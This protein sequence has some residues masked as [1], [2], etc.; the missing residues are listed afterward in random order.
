[1]VKIIVSILTVTFLFW[2]RSHAQESADSTTFTPYEL[3]SSYY[4]EGFKPFRKGNAYTGLSFSLTDK[5]LTN[6][7]KIFGQVINGDD[8]N[9]N[10]LFKGGYYLG[11]YFMVGFNFNYY[12]KKITGEVFVDPDSIQANSIT[13]GYGFAPNIRS[14]IP[15]TANERFSFFVALGLNFGV[16]NTLDRNITNLDEIS[17][18]YSTEYTFG[19]GISPGVTFFAMENFAFEVQ[20]NVLGYN[21]Q[22]TDTKID[23]QEDAKDVRHN[24]NFSIDILSLE[25]GLAYYI[26]S[27]K[28]K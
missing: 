26:G 17:E 19:A 24:V 23:G 16:A 25:L 27:G 5:Q 2:S 9:Y 10:L 28:Q 7:E 8:L 6:T 12:Q 15:L 1:M 11:D 22:V 20:L 21:L 3:M 13:R 14:S 18:T 4:S